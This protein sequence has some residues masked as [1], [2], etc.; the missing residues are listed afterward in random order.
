MS[1]LKTATGIAKT[2]TGKVKDF[3]KV[4]DV[5][6]G[7]IPFV[8]PPQVAMGLKTASTVAGVLN[9]VA[10]TKLKVPTEAELKA[11]AAGQLDN[12]LKGVRREVSDT[13]SAIEKG[14][15]VVDNASEVLSKITWLL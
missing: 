7:A 4:L 10:G 15:T 12:I 14:A 13:L 3:R 2:L 9:S 1:I 5:N 6:P 11:I 8:F